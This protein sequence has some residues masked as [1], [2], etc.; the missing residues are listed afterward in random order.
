MA[1]LEF[2]CAGRKHVETAL[3]S[4]FAFHVC[5]FFLS[6]CSVPIAKKIEMVFSLLWK[7]DND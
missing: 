7:A 1:V 4:M 2:T 5:R 6:A 3:R